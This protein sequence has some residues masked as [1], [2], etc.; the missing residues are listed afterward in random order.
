MDID[1]RSRHS[2]DK[3]SSLELPDGL[4]IGGS[5]LGTTRSHP[6]P[7]QASS[8]SS[9]ASRYV[10]SWTRGVTYAGASFLVLAALS[11]AAFTAS[12]VMIFARSD[13]PLAIP[14]GLISWIV[15]M[16][17]PRPKVAKSKE[18]TTERVPPV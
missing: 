14:I 15:G 6:S 5:M 8:T 4:D 7:G 10:F 11:I 16:W 12:L 1:Q 18:R 3:L 13:L 17:S 2:A 9:G